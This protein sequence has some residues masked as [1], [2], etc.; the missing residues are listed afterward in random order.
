MNNSPTAPTRFTIREPH[1]ITYVFTYHW[2]DGRGTPAGTVALQS[3]DGSIFGPW[4]AS[5]TPGQ[6]GVPNANWEVRP[7][8]VIPAGTYTIVDSDPST[9][10]QNAQ[11]G[12]RGMAIV[13][14]FPTGTAPP[15]NTENKI[16]D[17]YLHRTKDYRIPLFTGWKWQPD[18]NDKDLDLVLSPDEKIG[19]FVKGTIS[20]LNAGADQAAALRRAA[21][22][23]APNYPGSTITETT[24][25]GKP[26]LRL[27]AYD[28]GDKQP[29]WFYFFVS[30]RRVYYL[31]AMMAPNTGNVAFPQELAQVLNGVEFL[32]KAPPPTQTAIKPPTRTTQPPPTTQKPPTTKPTG[33]FLTAIFENRSG[34]NVHIFQ[35]GDSFDPANRLA[36]GEKRE[37]QVRMTA[38]GRIK[39]IAGR[40]GQVL[41]TKF[42]TGDPDDMNRFPRVIFDGAALIITTGLR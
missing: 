14:G 13:K 18:T 36:P 20:D 42:W 5:G 21:N 19:I 1:Q 23:I 28:A 11:S 8:V 4:R 35:E 24:V 22:S 33:N 9:W 7:N 16:A 31:F 30:E 10:S 37:V 29:V 6:G 27:N 41:T 26:A 3:E 39:F 15:V 38:D 17:W 25:G 12:G 32:R 40:N 34:E 2:N